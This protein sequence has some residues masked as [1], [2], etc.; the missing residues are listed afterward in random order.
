M[1]SLSRRHLLGASLSALA[2]PPGVLVAAT[3]FEPAPVAPTG[4]RLFRTSDYLGLT[5]HRAPGEN[6]GGFPGDLRFT[7]C[8]VVVKR[9]DRVYW[10]QEW[11]IEISGPG[12]LDAVLPVVMT[13]RNALPGRQVAVYYVEDDEPVETVAELEDTLA[14]ILKL[15]P[16]PG[17][18]EL[19]ISLHNHWD[20][21]LRMMHSGLPRKSV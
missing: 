17:L 7:G 10:S 8:S 15:E 2:I 1:P 19:K 21:A 3:A 18:E 12:F 13:W 14:S 4:V 6:N 20:D 11:K 9:R 16:P 5:L